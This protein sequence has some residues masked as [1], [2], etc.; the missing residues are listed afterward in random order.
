M[1]RTSAPARITL[2]L[3]AVA[4]AAACMAWAAPAAAVDTAYIGVHVGRNDLDH[5]DHSADFG[6]GVRTPG[7]LSLDSKT[8]WGLTAGRQMDLARF[9]L[10]YQQGQFDVT[11]FTLGALSGVRSA[12]GDF[13]A[14]TFNAYRS[15]PLNDQANVYLG[16]G[17]GIGH[18]KLPAL[19]RV[20]ACDCYRE[21]SDTGLTVQLRAGAEYAFGEGHRVFLQY[22]LMRLPRAGSDGTPSVDY[23]RE[24]VNTLSLGYG[25]AF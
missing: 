21:A 10:E 3:A 1:I 7:R 24:T 5:W 17:L 12:S 19:A 20:S 9:E 4:M 13:R 11:G 6:A 14:L 25:R 22:T 8:Q 16:G 2:R 15:F 18:S 23:S